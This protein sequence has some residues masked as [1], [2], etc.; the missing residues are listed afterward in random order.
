[1]AVMA[2]PF[3]AFLKI[4]QL[5]PVVVVACIYLIPTGLQG[6]SAA[7][8]AKQMRFRLLS[9]IGAVTAMI[10]AAVTLALALVGFGYWSLVLCN[11][12]GGVARTVAILYVQPCR[13]A[14]PRFRMVREP[15]LFGWRVVVS[16]LALNSYQRF[17]NLIAGKM[18]GQTALGLYGTA[19]SL[20]N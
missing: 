3:A 7:T 19:W 14:W 13:L 17:D 12:V 16:M 20:A 8:L 18:L 1:A 9:V 15:L 5:A 10:A 6:V 11:L 2:K 4:P